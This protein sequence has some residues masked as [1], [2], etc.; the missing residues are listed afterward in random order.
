MGTSGRRSERA[1]SKVASA[2]AV[3]GVDTGLLHLAVALKVPTVA[4]FGATDPA[5]TGPV[6]AGPI[7]VCR[8]TSEAVP[9]ATVLAALHGL[10]GAQ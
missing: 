6:G 1:S 9:V 5:L 10:L 7:T 4:I 8:A 2:R 3:I